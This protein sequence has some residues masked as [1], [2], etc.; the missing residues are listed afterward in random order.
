MKMKKLFKF[1]C[2]MAAIVVGQSAWAQ[3]KGV[4]VKNFDWEGTDLNSIN[5]SASPRPRFEK[6]TSDDFM[7]VNIASAGH[8]VRFVSDIDGAIMKS[9]F[10]SF[11]HTEASELNLGVISWAPKTE[12]Y[13]LHVK[14]IS[15]YTKIGGTKCYYMLGD[16]LV[17]SL[18]R[19]SSG[20][21]FV[22]DLDY[23]W[24]NQSV[25]NIPEDT[26]SIAFMFV[27]APDR[28]HSDAGLGAA[29]GRMKMEYYVTPD[30]PE[31][32]NKEMV[33]T[34]D[35]N[36]IHWY[37]LSDQVKINPAFASTLKFDVKS[38]GKNSS[39]YMVWSATEDSFYVVKPLKFTIKARI[40]SLAG[41]YSASE[42]TTW[43][44]QAKI[45]Q[46]TPQIFYFV[47]DVWV[48]D[49]NAAKENYVDFFV[50]NPIEHFV[51][52]VCA[53]K[54]EVQYIEKSTN[55]VE[56]MTSPRDRH[57]YFNFKKSV[58][59]GQTDVI[60]L[61]I[62]AAGSSVLRM[63][64]IGL[65]LNR[66]PFLI[67]TK[68]KCNAL[69]NRDAFG[70]DTVRARWEDNWTEDGKS[71]ARQDVVRFPP[72][73]FW[74][75][76][77]PRVYE[78]H[79]LGVPD[80]LFYEYGNAVTNSD[81]GRL[82]VQWSADGK[83]WQDVRERIYGPCRPSK[84][85]E[86]Y[87]SLKLDR[88]AQYLRFIYSTATKAAY[89]K[90][91]KV[92]T[93]KQLDIL[94]QDTLVNFGVLLRNPSAEPAVKKDSLS[95]I[96]LFPELLYTVD[97]PFSADGR[98]PVRPGKFDTIRSHNKFN[99]RLSLDTVGVFTKRL[100]VASMDVAQPMATY[101]TLNG[102]VTYDQKDMFAAFKDLAYTIKNDTIN[103][104][105]TAYL[106]IKD[107]LNN[108]LK[109]DSLIVSYE[110]N[111]DSLKIE[112]GVVSDACV[113][114]HKIVVKAQKN[115]LVPFEWSNTLYIYVR[116]NEED[117]ITFNFSSADEIAVHDTLTVSV[118]DED[119]KGKLVFWTEDP[120]AI[121]YSGDSIFIGSKTFVSDS[122]TI[123]A[124]APQTC[125]HF[126]KVDS[127]RIK[128][129]G[130]VNPV[131]TFAPHQWFCI[132]G[133]T[134]VDPFVV[135]D[136]KKLDTLTSQVNIALTFTPR[137][138]VDSLSDGSWY[139]NSSCEDSLAVQAVVSS[140]S[141][142]T[143]TVSVKFA[144]ID[145]ILN[146]QFPGTVDDR[147]FYFI[148]DVLKNED[149]R[150][151]VGNEGARKD[152]DITS[153]LTLTKE[154]EEEADGRIFA[155]G[156]VVLDSINT[157]V[158]KVCAS[159]S[160]IC[161]T[162][163]ENDSLI[164]LPARVAE[165]KFPGTN[166]DSIFVVG[167][168]IPVVDI[169]V[170]DSV[171]R[172]LDYYVRY[173][174]GYVP[175]DFAHS[176]AT[177]CD[178]TDFVVLDK[179]GLDTTAVD[180]LISN[181]VGQLVRDTTFSDRLLIAPVY[182]VS[183]EMP[184]DWTVADTISVADMIA[185]DQLKAIDAKGRDATRY[186]TFVLAAAETD[187]KR[188]DES[189]LVLTKAGD[190]IKLK[191]IAKQN[192]SMH[193]G[194]IVKFLNVKP[195]KVASVEWPETDKMLFDSYTTDSVKLFDAKGVNITEY[196]TQNF[197]Y[198]GKCTWEKGSF[199][200]T[201]TGSYTLSDTIKAGNVADTVL[202]QEITVKNFSPV[203]VKFNGDD[204]VVG[205]A[206]ELNR[207]GLVVANTTDEIDEQY[208]SF[209]Y[210]LVDPMDAHW[211]IDS[212]AFV[213][214]SLQAQVKVKIAA[215][216]QVDMEDTVVTIDANP[217]TADRVV[218][219][220]KDFLVGEGFAIAELEVY[221][222]NNRNITRYAK[223][224]FNSFN[225]KPANRA[226][227]NAAQDSIIFT[228]FGTVT[229]TVSLGK[230]LV[231]E[232]SDDYKLS[233]DQLKATRIE[234]PAGPYI[235]GDKL[236]R[237][238]F[239]V[240][241]GDKEVTSLIEDLS[242][243]MKAGEGHAVD[244]GWMMDQKGNEIVVT[245]EVIGRS[246]SENFVQRDTI[247]VDPVTV[248]RMELLTT[249]YKVMDHI[250]LN[251]IRFYDANDSNI[252]RYVSPAYSWTPAMNAHMGEGYIELDVAGD[253]SIIAN[254]L[255]GNAKAEKEIA[256]DVRVANYEGA[257]IVLDQKTFEVGDTLTP[258]SFRLVDAEGNTLSPVKGR[259][260]I[261]CATPEYGENL[262]DGNILFNKAGIGAATIEAEFVDGY[263]ELAEAFSEKVSI[264]AV[265]VKKL[266]FE[267]VYA[268]GD[269][270]RFG[271]LKM[272]NADDEDITRYAKNAIKMMEEQ[273]DG[274]AV[275]SIKNRTIVLNKP[276]KI[277]IT[278]LLQCKDSI[279]PSVVE[280]DLFVDNIEPTMIVFPVKDYKVGDKMLTKDVRVLA[281]GVDITRFADVTLTID[282]RDA[283]YVADGVVF[284]LKNANTHVTAKVGGYTG[285]KAIVSDTTYNVAAVEAE[286]VNLP[287]VAAVMQVINTANL[288]FTDA[289]GRDITEYA[290][291]V[292]YSFNNEK[293]RWDATTNSIICDSIGDVVVT[294]TL[295]GNAVGTIE[296]TIT[297]Q[298]FV[299][300]KIAYAKADSTF[301]VADMVE[302]RDFALVD[303]T[304]G[305]LIYTDYTLSISC[306]AAD[307][308]K[309][310]DNIRLNNQGR[311]KVTASVQGQVKI[312]DQEFYL[313]VKPAKAAYV[314]YPEDGE[315]VVGKSIKIED[316]VVKDT[317]NR[318]LTRYLNV[319]DF[320][321]V[322]DPLDAAKQEDD[323]IKFYKAGKMYITA[324]FGNN[325]VE[326]AE[327][328][329]MLSIDQQEA[330]YFT[331][332]ERLYQVGDTLL[333]SDVAIF[334]KDSNDITE[335]DKLFFIFKNNTAHSV[336]EGLVFDK[337][338]DFDLKIGIKGYENVLKFA[339]DTTLSVAPRRVK[340]VI[341]PVTRL[342]VLDS[343]N[344]DSIKVLDIWGNDMKDTYAELEITFDTDSAKWAGKKIVFLKNGP[345]ALIISVKGN[346][347]G[348][349]IE[350]VTVDKN[351]TATITVP[352]R[353]FYYVG[354]IVKLGDFDLV[355]KNGNKFDA[356]Y[357]LTFDIDPLYGRKLDAETIVIDTLDATIEVAALGEVDILNATFDPEIKPCVV[358]TVVFP[359]TNFVVGDSIEIAKLTLLD[360]INRDLTRYAEYQRIEF[361]PT[362]AAKADL[363]KGYIYFLEPGI[364][365][366]S[367]FVGKNKMAVATLEN[368]IFIE[369]AAAAYVAIEN[370]QRT[371]GDT[372]D[373]AEVIAYDKDGNEITM[374]SDL[375][376]SFAP[377]EAHY[378][379]LGL[380]DKIILDKAGNNL[381]DVI[382]DGRK[383]VAKR[384]L[385]PQLEISPVAVNSVE[386]LGNYMVTGAIDTTA[387]RAYAANGLDITR[388]VATM[389]Y[390]FDP[391][392]AHKDGNGYIFDKSGD[393]NISV[394]LGGSD[395]V[396][397]TKVVVK[398]IAK[399][400]ADQV[401]FPSVENN[402]YRVGDVIDSVDFVVLD[403]QGN[404]ITKY[405]TLTFVSKPATMAVVNA[406]G[407][408]EVKET[409]NW[410]LDVV[411]GGDVE[412][413]T[414]SEN[415]F[416]RHNTKDNKVYDLI[417]RIREDLI[418][419]DNNNDTLPKFVSY[420][421]FKDEQVVAGVTTQ[422]Y[423][424]RDEDRDDKAHVMYAIATDAAGKQY[425]LKEKTYVF[426]KNPVT[427]KAVSIKSATYLD[428]ATAYVVETSDAGQVYVSNTNGVAVDRFQVE[429]GKNQAVT[430]ASAGVFVLHFTTT[431]GQ[432]ATQKIIVK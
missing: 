268:L 159:A 269:T 110:Y 120:E 56:Y 41:G 95:W 317:L 166:P 380:V 345:V 43:T 236:M 34:V 342:E 69:K 403:A 73:D 270:V 118:F 392:V 92:T 261:S 49:V 312:S 127:I 350:V 288:I 404:D 231:N 4:V 145:Y 263:V 94:P 108:I 229:V 248:D 277:T 374:Y 28:K 143:A 221:D 67:D 193:S 116:E 171:G 19:V 388:Y 8:D 109:H 351:T 144:I 295:D 112:D 412:T 128:V 82:Y 387:I 7:V 63:N 419:I 348:D 74:A 208:Y 296:K 126:E 242:I 282:E 241:A 329:N 65:E 365:K 361:M 213:L 284:D 160:F 355:D 181:I 327:I 358:K 252:T 84:G 398:N 285:V 51:E 87:D 416:V 154:F 290:N 373:I 178:S 303:K 167:D 197:V 294:V 324:A 12:R 336:D 321:F 237:D 217:C 259:I 148:A 334:D 22:E 212:K 352:Q 353:D 2:M 266:V 88:S 194:L 164:V 14:G 254:I 83:T 173:E 235:V 153:R 58:Q 100:K 81:N 96:N 115:T 216:S 306:A 405:A 89:V 16:T 199:V 262:A 57:D 155:N 409:G 425:L 253:A 185:K 204:F 372:L 203:E 179:N 66:V 315:Y 410:Q 325:L 149:F 220:T 205:D 99:I 6:T 331:M 408:I 300:A 279:A 371:V 72:A 225:F 139:I 400:V 45:P 13:K 132:G 86:V 138:I 238:E 195:V 257:K 106:V 90:N 233:S 113:G 369:Q 297:I 301:Y 360:S 302:L 182:A 393:Q 50:T 357:T 239:R 402:E 308:E 344:T 311:I 111:A 319:T 394:T 54:S 340:E 141:I 354:D 30:A 196:A 172:S 130:I 131:F 218:F 292:S 125:E 298:P 381:I 228:Q 423:Y 356:D 188:I 36:N 152:K 70:G 328:T 119:A 33:V 389:A 23:S 249:T 32:L 101:V 318:D 339:F 368:K 165:W 363:T 47:D 35:T 17:N 379:V 123:F 156:D 430:P 183:V 426:M 62:G 192:G 332:E 137:E 424:V 61:Q 421:W 309:V 78:I 52:Y 396:P 24:L 413:A 299:D 260:A 383:G 406:Q 18:Q 20:W 341:L 207:F 202:T 250:L 136:E 102:T 364:V 431:D 187:A 273:P 428:V 362:T 323:S 168:S 124:K 9:D 53:D 427:K 93:L 222:V 105:D 151:L 191:L 227:L 415:Y 234:L 60:R 267:D 414:F 150:V 347:I 375:Q 170:K 385:T 232:F 190:N 343:L 359:D 255:A 407:N 230:E 272:L 390:S 26:N 3:G 293:A 422:N 382:V 378:A 189:T 80:S 397:A 224:E 85:G 211:T 370:Y 134:L 209:E 304:S 274:A 326:H 346:A 5:E 98:I 219:P 180:T 289:E 31:Y 246:N 201:Q 215:G 11:G 305:R 276:G 417:E 322:S 245:T 386:I 206:V 142:K 75:M 366:A 429:E 37:S 27:G 411:L 122:L 48:R 307:G 384:T 135:L 337:A 320:L 314:I 256:V 226:R 243:S 313:T 25:Y 377:D 59:Q 251:T 367:T 376:F 129:R 280:S 275:I 140:D 177:R 91:I 401:I 240:F 198:A 330:A 133:D 335:N 186:A 281:N 210:E 104:G 271:D 391:G 21:A 244:G 258:A 420:V 432:V 55:F 333:L 418:L 349:T 162:T 175:S 29:L 264:S 163:C 114:M 121:T 79:F 146:L 71:Y 214:D 286:D 338:G 77:D 1:V 39:K 68:E 278:T 15:T 157:S 158:L 103:Y 38:A 40:D 265:E 176:T 283:H 42:T 10:L 200:L 316:I 97:D 247:Q 223:N 44:I 287:G 64:A 107:S 147:G 174:F 161:D 76:D 117:T 399:C 395:I 310:G 291:V 184:L 46:E 169:T